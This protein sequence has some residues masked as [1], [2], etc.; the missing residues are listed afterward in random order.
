MDGEERIVTESKTHPPHAA[1]A[2]NVEW[3]EEFPILERIVFLNHAAVSPLP[4]RAARALLTYAEEACQNG[5]VAWPRW[6]ARAKQARQRAAQLLG[7]QPDEIAFVRST[8]HGIMCIAQ[9]LRW[10]PGDN[11]LI[12]E[13]EFPANVYPW[14]NLAER[15][16]AVRTVPERPDHRFSVDDFAARIDAHTRLIAVS[17]V[18]Y[19]TGY[20]MPVERLAELCRERGILLC[21]DGI[22]GVGAMPVDV[23]AIGCDFLAADG[24]KWMLGPEGAG[25]LYV[26]QERIGLF[27][28]SMT[29][30]MTRVRSWDYEDTT[31]PVVNSAKRFEEG[32]YNMPGIQALDASVSLLLE[33]GPAEVFRRIEAL[34]ARLDEGLRKRGYEV[35][36]PRGEGER[37]GILVFR[38]EGLDPAECVKRLEEREIYVTA[39]RGWV[40]VSPHFYNQPEQIDRLLAALK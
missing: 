26:N 5:A 32:A 35:V 17:L 33:V 12:G 31:Q 36:S 25:Y 20:R 24:H 7:S 10:R 19:S 28:E 27:N 21:I 30:W 15:G 14:K 29:G 38:R 1:A 34:N 37:S 22:Q 23:K 11:V 16:V 8:T 2:D 13:H 4:A 3:L 6:A 9:S 39:R 18:Q 40:R